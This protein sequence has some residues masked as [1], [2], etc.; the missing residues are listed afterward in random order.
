[1]AKLGPGAGTRLVQYEGIGSVISAADNDRQ[2]SH[3]WK[4]YLGT[5]ALR[6]A[7]GLVE[8]RVPKIGGKPMTDVDLPLTGK[9]NADGES[10]V[11]VEAKTVPVAAT[12]TT[13]A[14]EELQITLVHTTSPVSRAADL[15]RHPVA[16]ILWR[17]ERPFR[18]LPITY[19]HLR[20]QRVVLSTGGTRHVFV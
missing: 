7:L 14:S 12:S 3:P 17:E 6:L 15:G 2:W 18:A 13:E 9:P 19:F 10:W 8:N 20:Y 11:C 1:M 4:P 16:L 5:S